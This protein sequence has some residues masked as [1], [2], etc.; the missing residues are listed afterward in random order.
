M[1]MYDSFNTNQNAEKTI[2]N[3]LSV[4]NYRVIVFENL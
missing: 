4:D 2:V 3:I 1:L